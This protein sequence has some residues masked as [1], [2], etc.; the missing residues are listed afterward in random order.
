M[1]RREKK[2]ILVIS[3]EIRADQQ[4]YEFCINFDLNIGYEDFPVKFELLSKIVWI[5][6]QEALRGLLVKSYPLRYYIS[7]LWMEQ[8]KLKVNTVSDACSSQLILKYG[9]R[10]K[11]SDKPLTLSCLLVTFS[12]QRLSQMPLVRGQEVRIRPDF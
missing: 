6:I 3:S 5:W 9:K 1:Q 10:T 11:S 7:M 8:A 12:P 2:K 4:F